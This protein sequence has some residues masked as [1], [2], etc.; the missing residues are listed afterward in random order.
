VSS[1]HAG[2]FF[3]AIP[4]QLLVLASTIPHWGSQLDCV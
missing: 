3:N 2:G 1:R 4:A